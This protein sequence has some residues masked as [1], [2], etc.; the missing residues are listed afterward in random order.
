MGQLVY[1]APLALVV[2]PAAK[3]M[4]VEMTHHAEA[5]HWVQGGDTNSHGS[6]V[7]TDATTGAMPSHAKKARLADATADTQRSNSPGCTAPSNGVSLLMTP[8]HEM[9]VQR[10]TTGGK[11]AKREAE[12]SQ[13]AKVQAQERCCASASTT[14]CDCARL[15]QRVSAA[16]QGSAASTP[17]AGIAAAGTRASRVS[18]GLCSTGPL[19]AAQLGFTA[20][21]AGGRLPGTVRL[22]GSA[23][24]RPPA[25]RT[26]SP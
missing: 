15:H 10:G 25:R 17:G 9:Y 26:L 23:A 18:D 7:Y 2:K 3:Q 8:D 22:P 21:R 5:R 14:C 20:P 19:F 12:F 1:E 16:A 11:S 4:L 13:F 6:D 24:A